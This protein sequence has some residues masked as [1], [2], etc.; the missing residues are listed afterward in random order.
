M[1]ATGDQ[2]A[3]W[4]AALAG[5]APPIHADEPAAGFYETRSKN[6]AT[7]EVTRGVVA[8]WYAPDGALCC[9]SGAAMLD[10]LRARERWPY[11][12][13]RPITKEVY[14]AVRAG[15]GWPDESPAAAADRARA[16]T[17]DGRAR[18]NAAEVDPNSLAVMRE[19]AD[20][21]TREAERLIKAG[22]AKTQD[23]SDQA[24]DLADRLLKLEKAADERRRAEMRPHEE[25]AAEVDGQWRPLRDRAADCKKRLK[26]V[27]VTPFLAAIDD[28]NKKAAAEAVQRGE[29]AAAPAP[30]KTTSGTTSTV[31]LR[32]VKSAR[33][34]DY[35]KALAYFA[36]NLKVRELIQQLANAAIRSGTTP[37]GCELHETKSA[38]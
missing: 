33:I 26:V 34:T 19:R 12:S 15:K 37:D 2:W 35:P 24:A 10:D 11:A 23:A 18:P 3:W 38:A 13:K 20:D 7:G 27:V 31:G 14:D 30:R 25:A 5:G 6:K 17:S 29:P 21:L 22:A 4:R 8:Y 9:K 36:E 1:T 16:A 32:G 28:A